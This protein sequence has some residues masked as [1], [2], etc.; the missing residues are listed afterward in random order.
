MTA[1]TIQVRIPGR[2]PRS[3]VLQPGE[4]FTLGRS[5]ECDAT[6]T[7]PNLSR[8]ALEL[9]LRPNGVIA[10]QANQRY[11]H[12]LVRRPDGSTAAR[13]QKG[14]QF[15]LTGGTGHLEVVGSMGPLASLEL[16]TTAPPA[17][18]AVFVPGEGGEHTGGQLQYAQI[19]GPR[20]PQWLVVAALAAVLAA[21]ARSTPPGIYPGHRERE[22]LR[23]ACE[24]WF[25]R[26]STAGWLT[27]RLEE[28]LAEL[29]LVIPTGADKV[30]PIAEHLLDSKTMTPETLARLDKELTLRAKKQERR[31]TPP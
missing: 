24:A 13:L 8:K 23:I 22:L 4:R 21:R 15:A 30:P 3:L 25:A 17:S 19:A 31:A 12:V 29:H 20:A 26:P 7:S 2:A 9:R 16:T 5:A 14:E 6:D 11:G 10:I 1:T 27:N 28:A 18:N